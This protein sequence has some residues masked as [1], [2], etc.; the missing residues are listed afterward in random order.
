MI[1]DELVSKTN[2]LNELKRKT[3][4]KNNKALQDNAD[5]KY[6]MILSQTDSFVATIDYLYS[7]NS[8]LKNVEVLSATSELLCSLQKVIESGLANSDEIGKAEN[9]YKSIQT[10]MK[11]EWSKLYAQITGSTI[12]TLEAIKGIDSENV[13]LLGNWCKEIMQYDAGNRR[14][15]SA[16][17]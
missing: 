17:S 16:Y 13:G 7:N 6:R 4:L 3:D 5:A 15:R 2:A 9:A 14:R 12:S 8:S 10:N 1:F 11:K